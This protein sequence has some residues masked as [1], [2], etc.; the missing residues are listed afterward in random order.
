MS[1]KVTVDIA[2]DVTDISVTEIPTSVTISD[3]TNTITV[4]ENTTTVNIA[5]VVTTVTATEQVTTVD[6]SENLTTV[7]IGDASITAS[8]LASTIQTSHDS[9]SW[10]TGASVQASLDNIATT[11]DSRYVNVTGDTMTGDLTVPRL[12]VEKDNGT[13]V[14]TL[15][16]STDDDDHIIY[17]T[18]MVAN[19][20][21]N[22]FSLGTRPDTNQFQ[23]HSYLDRNFEFTF[24]SSR[25]VDPVAT[26]STSGLDVA[27]TITFDGGTTSANLNFGD[28]DKA[29]FGNSSDLQM[30]HSG[31]HSFITDVGEGNLYIDAREFYVRNDTGVLFQSTSAGS[32]HMLYADNTKL[33]TTAN[34]VD[35]TGT[36]TFD[37]GTTSA[38]LDFPDQVHL[39]FGDDSDLRIYHDGTAS[40]IDDQGD[41]SL[42]IRANDLYLQKYTGANYFSAIDGGATTLFYNGSPKI[43]TTNTG[44]TVTGTATATAFSGPLTGNVTGQVS[45]ISNHDTGD[46]TEGANLY[47]TTARFNTAFGGKSTSDLSEGTNLYY[48]DARADARISNALKDED[49]MASNSA[50]HVPSQQSVKAYVDTEVAGLVD[51]SP[52]ALDTLNELAAALGDDANFSTTVTDSIGTKLAKASNLSDLTNAGTARTNLGL[53]TAATTSSTDYATA[54]QGSKADT[55]YGWGNHADAGYGT[56]NLTIGSGADQAMAGNTSLTTTLGGLTDVDAT[57]GLAN[58][59]ILKYNSTDSEWQV[60]DDA[61]GITL[62]DISVNG[63]EATASGDGGIAYD[64]STGVFQYTPPTAAG[65]GAVTSVSA[66]VTRRDT[67]QPVVNNLAQW[68]YNSTTGVTT[69]VTT[70]HH[71]FG[72][73]DHIRI[74]DTSGDVTEGD[75]GPVT[76]THF[77]SMTIVANIGV[78]TDVST[79]SYVKLDNT[80]PYLKISDSEGNSTSIEFAGADGVSVE[81]TTDNKITIDNGY[82]DI[83]VDNY[84]GKDPDLLGGSV[85]NKD[86][87]WLSG[88]DFTDTGGTNITYATS[89][90]YTGEGINT[91]KKQSGQ[92]YITGEPFSINGI[93]ISSFKIKAASSLVIQS[94]NNSNLSLRSPNGYSASVNG[95]NFYGNYGATWTSPS[96]MT[97]PMGGPGS[98]QSPRVVLTTDDTGSNRVLQIG[99]TKTNIASNLFD[100]IRIQP[101]TKGV[102]IHRSTGQIEN[103]MSGQ[104]LA[105]HTTDNGVHVGNDRRGTYTAG[106]LMINQDLDFGM[107]VGSQCQNYG[108]NN[109]GFGFDIDFEDDTNEN[110]SMGARNTIKSHVSDSAAIGGSIQLGNGSNAITGVMAGGFLTKTTKDYAFTWA[111]GYTNNYDFED[112][113]ENFAV[114]GVM[115]GGQSKLTASAMRSFVGGGIG[116]NSENFEPHRVDS[117][118][119]FN[120]GKSNNIKS[121]SHQSAALGLYHILD[122]SPQCF[123]AGEIQRLTNTRGSAAVGALHNITAGDDFCFAAGYSNEVFGHG[124]ACIGYELKTPL[125]RHL[126]TDDYDWEDYCTVVGGW[127]DPSKKFATT[128][129]GSTWVQNQRFVVGTG[130]DGSPKTGFVVAAPTS[131]F[132]GIIMTHLAESTSHAN[133]AAAKAAGVPV[134]GLYRTGNDVKILL[135]TD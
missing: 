56:S 4:E 106:D 96:T 45:D 135:A 115:F 131:D 53:G 74:F 10:V 40:Y 73:G 121:G 75:Y 133:P 63:T 16:D 20:P 112:Y 95:F 84:L 101:G 26:V 89:A 125:N 113:A 48:T 9:G 2:E 129:N 105:F 59:K 62:T 109:F 80:N 21:E 50:T 83:N 90:K 99:G 67:S 8:N 120:Y 126:A 28:G 97:A 100:E 79:V 24:G 128:S 33:K 52:A 43:A 85:Y 127:N 36:I 70:S 5:P 55:A 17:L 60:A 82:N 49:N 42:H 88:E 13:A 38:P 111:N 46:L 41:G 107:L 72:I 81:R 114:G 76:V 86:L 64:N 61:G 35:V 104:V 54:T 102:R 103:V 130:T 23:L 51:G 94:G 77:N 3:P 110:F 39:R 93:E 25:T 57:T 66:Q 15:H 92:S 29:V 14:I 122:T 134:G 71:G 11:A 19:S 91:F 37:G 118:Y 124:G 47:Y 132:S 32:S 98:G 58:D 123:V 1:D 22:L 44:V 27:G 119:C 87:L 12:R 116:G 69:I 31:S 108:R 68:S 34:G 7:G 78:P 6:I 18:G 117:Q 30:Y 65:I